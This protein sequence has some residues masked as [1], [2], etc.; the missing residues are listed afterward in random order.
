MICMACDP[1]TPKQ[2][3]AGPPDPNSGSSC[4]WTEVE[5]NA[6]TMSSSDDQGHHPHD[7]EAPPPGN[8][9]DDDQHSVF[10]AFS[11]LGAFPANVPMKNFTVVKGSHVYGLIID[12]GAA[13]GL[14]GSESLREIIQ[15]VLK[16][17][18]QDKYIKWQKSNNSFTGISADPQSS[19]GMVKFPIGL[20]GMPHA[21]FRADVL[22]GAASKCPGLVPL[23]SLQQQGCVIACGYFKNGDGLL[24]IRLSSGAFNTQRLLLTDSGHYLMP[25]HYFG[26]KAHDG[27]NKLLNHDWRHLDRHGQ[28]LRRGESTSSPTFAIECIDAKASNDTT[29]SLFQ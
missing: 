26:S 25:I 16:P 17:A 11:S 29:S 5:N 21:S 13:R 3:R 8:P 2:P 27:L 4:S 9:D 24:G 19:I 23:Q 12:P 7:D 22:G 15:H 20:M 1:V 18:K 14:I 10:M 28:R 6:Y